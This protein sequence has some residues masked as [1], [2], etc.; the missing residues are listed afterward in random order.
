MKFVNPWL[1]LTIIP[2]VIL[3]ITGFLIIRKRKKRL[4][5]LILGASA[6]DPAACS[7]SKKAVWF[8][9]LP[10]FVWSYG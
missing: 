8:M 3:W 10:R 2:A 6:D 1:L 4:L 5:S 7:L 9:G